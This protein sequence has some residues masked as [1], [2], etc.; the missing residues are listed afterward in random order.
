[1]KPEHNYLFVVAAPSG[2]GKSSL[3]KAVSH[4]NDDI[5]VSISYTTRP[6]RHGEVDGVHYHFIDTKT[7]ETMIANHE[8]LEYAKVMSQ[9][10]DYY[11]GTGKN[12]V[13]QQLAAGKHVILEIDWQG[14]EQIFRLFPQARG[15]FI[16]PPSLTVLRQR[17]EQRGRDQPADIDAR[18]SVARDEISHYRE[19]DYL[20]VNDDFGHSVKKL[21]DI[22]A[23]Q[24]SPNGAKNGELAPD[25]QRLLK[26]LLA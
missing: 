1:M 2:A 18:M 21:T 20:M 4:D 14:A 6:P 8:L 3:V 22:F 23:D 26:D 17:L 19:Y 5:V 10:Q 9:I 7:F 25:L 15:I 24:Q 12:W 16:L 11:Y 13:E